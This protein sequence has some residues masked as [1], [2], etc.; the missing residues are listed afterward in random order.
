MPTFFKGVTKFFVKTE[1]NI[2]IGCFLLLLY[3]DADFY[4]YLSVLST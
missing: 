1:K 4:A 2:L 3:I